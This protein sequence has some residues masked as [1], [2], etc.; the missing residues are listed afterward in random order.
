MRPPAIH[1]KAIPPIDPASAAITLGDRKMPTPIVIPIA[2]AIVLQIPS[3]P[4]SPSSAEVPEAAT[5]L[6]LGHRGAYDVLATD[7]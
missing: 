3:W 5:V 2:S 6:T 1:T 4:G 7:R